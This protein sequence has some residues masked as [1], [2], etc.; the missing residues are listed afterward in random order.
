MAQV[1]I[2][3]LHSSDAQQDPTENFP[4]EF[5]LIAPVED[6]VVR[7]KRLEDACTKASPLLIPAPKAQDSAAFTK[8]A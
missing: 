3:G 6:H 2:H 8:L 7:R 1:S 5:V 4:A